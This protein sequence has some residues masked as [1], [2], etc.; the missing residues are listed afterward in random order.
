[1]DTSFVRGDHL[2]HIENQI[3]LEERRIRS[4]K[5]LDI[6]HFFLVSG[7]NLTQRNG[8]YRRI[9]KFSK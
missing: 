1:M 6:C 7:L 3:T 9:P 2:S 8:D 4:H 5:I